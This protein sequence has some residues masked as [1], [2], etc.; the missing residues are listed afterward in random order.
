[1][2]GKRGKKNTDQQTPQDPWDPQEEAFERLSDKLTATFSQGFDKLQ[3]A[4]VNIAEQA[5]SQSK[6]SSQPKR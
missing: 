1:M 3:Q 6:D 4:L 5:A 2:P